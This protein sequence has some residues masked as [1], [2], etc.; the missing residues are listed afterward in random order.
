M[1]DDESDEDLKRAIALSL[2]ESNPSPAEGKPAV[3][4]LISDD[5]D[6]DLDAPVM[7]KPVQSA[8]KVLEEKQSL[9]ERKAPSGRGSHE[10]SKAEGS[11]S[12]KGSANISTTS[13]IPGQNPSMQ[14]SCPPTSGILGLNRKQ[15]EEE[16]LARVARLTASRGVGLDESKSADESKKRRAVALSPKT[17]DGRNVKAKISTSSQ[18]LVPK[19]VAS[20]TV[21]QHSNSVSSNGHRIGPGSSGSGIQ[22]PDGVVKKT[23]AYGCP[24]DGND[25][26]I[27]EV[28]QK[29]D[30]EL[31]V[32]SAFQIDS[33]WIMSKLNEKTKVVWVLQAKSEAEKENWRDQAPKK[34]RFCFPSMDGI[35][36]CMHSK[37]QLLAHGSYLRIVV[38]SANL[39]TADPHV[40]IFRFP[41]TG[42]RVELWKMFAALSMVPSQHLNNAGM[43][44]CFLID[45]PKL[46]AGESAE[47]TTQF[48]IELSYFLTALGMDQKIVDSLRKFD[49]SNTADI[50]FVHTIFPEHPTNSP[51]PVAAPTIRLGNGRG[52]ADSG[53]L[54]KNSAQLPM[55]P[56]RLTFS[57][58]TNPTQ[59]LMLTLTQA[60]SIG[61]LNEDFI[62]AMCLACQGDDGLTEYGWRTGKS[63]RAKGP[64]ETKRKPSDDFL[65]R[66]RVYFPTEETVSRSK[67][68]TQVNQPQVMKDH[69]STAKFY[70]GR[71]NANWPSPEEQFVSKRTIP[72]IPHA[73]LCC[74]ETGDV[75]A[76]EDDLHQGL[77]KSN[78]LRWKCESL[79]ICLFSSSYAFTIGF[80]YVPSRSAP[81]LQKLAAPDPD[82]GL[83]NEVTDSGSARSPT[84]KL[85]LEPEISGCF[86][87]LYLKHVPITFCK[88][89]C[90]PASAQRR[91]KLVK[92]R[93]SKQPKLNCRNWECGVLVS[94]S[95]STLT[96]KPSEGEEGGQSLG[97]EVFDGV[98]PVPMLTPGE[99]YGAR[100]PWYFAQH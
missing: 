91:G 66:C 30:L 70:C 74:P 9:N 4:D 94:A 38:P 57:F 100:K 20:D 52:I 7:A 98:V 28:L 8:F 80:L 58:E 97:M 33:D 22:Y 78:G 36:N 86:S 84:L 54:S 77:S 59:S 47:L 25:I 51:R 24:R 26:K 89:L 40:L 79:R 87:I 44:V 64:G 29:D 75:D 90:T 16:R 88:V 85:Q 65:S 67:G 43:G 1:S 56:S 81:A 3:I 61:N 13:S 82:A 69:N 31:A 19:A 42:V 76:F 49:F 48:G 46:P 96:R 93:T 50:G 95:G 68:G 2:I 63:T 45:L 41:M 35:I 83:S 73:R 23:W 11:S 5:E 55:K 53:K 37:L 92:D 14:Q 15:M 21:S 6:D 32:L 27:E 17:H 99:P 34:Y 60:A 10:A 18:L 12:E 71:G 62:K 72:E 39:N